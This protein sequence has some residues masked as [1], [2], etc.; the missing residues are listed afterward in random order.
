MSVMMSTTASRQHSKPVFLDL[1]ALVYG[2]I[3]GELCNGSS[4][5]GAP[6]LNCWHHLCSYSLFHPCLEEAEPLSA[7]KSS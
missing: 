3:E 5:L 6:I 4:S 1:C 2:G 7:I